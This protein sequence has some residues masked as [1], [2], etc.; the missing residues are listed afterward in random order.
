MKKLTKRLLIKI[1]ERVSFPAQSPDFVV[2]SLMHQAYQ[3]RLPSFA[4]GH[5]EIFAVG[6]KRKEKLL[7]AV[8]LNHTSYFFPS[9]PLDGHAAGRRRSSRDPLQYPQSHYSYYCNCWQSFAKSWTR[10][11]VGC[12]NIF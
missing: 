1:N 2:S 5:L 8:L 11:D 4:T 7:A 6:L 9:V 10:K 12:R 3:H